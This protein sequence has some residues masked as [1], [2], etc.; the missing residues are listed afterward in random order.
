MKQNELWP[1]TD[2]FDGLS[3][4]ISHVRYHTEVIEVIPH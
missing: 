1:R 4:L 2:H 3:Y